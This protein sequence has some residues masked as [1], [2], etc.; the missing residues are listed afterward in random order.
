MI[1]VMF[2][3]STVEMDTGQTNAEVVPV[4]RVADQIDEEIEILEEGTI[5]ERELDLV[6]EDILA[7]DRLLEITKRTLV[8]EPNRP[9]IR[10]RKDTNRKENKSKKKGRKDQNLE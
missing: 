6:E 10:K 1:K 9:R 7:A 8:E 4:E 2:D 5:I 3:E